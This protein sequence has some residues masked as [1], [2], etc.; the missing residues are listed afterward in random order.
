MV[1]KFY[2]AQDV[3]NADAVA[4][5]ELGVPS[6]LLMEN[7]AASA[8]RHITEKTPRGGTAVMLAG[9][10][11]NG[12]DAF[13]AARQLVS[14]G[15]NAVVFKTAN[16]ESYKNDAALNLSLLKKLCDT[17]AAAP[18][19][20]AV[21]IYDSEL[22]GDDFI[23]AVL[24]KSACICDALL[25]TG[26]HG[27]PRGEIARLIKLLS[28]RGNI[29]AFDIPS[30]IDPASGAVYEPCVSADTTVTFLAP[31]TG[32]AVFPACEK[33][34]AVTVGSI[35]VPP[36]CVLPKEPELR[37]WAASDIAS[38]I[39]GIPAD[40]HKTSRGS[41]L[42][43]AGSAEYRGAPLLAA[44]GA[45]RAGAGLVFLAVPDFIAE[46]ASQSLPEAIIV[47]LETKGGHIQAEKAIK[48]F[49]AYT[50]KCTAAAIGPGCGRGSECRDIFQWFWNTWE[51][52]LLLDADMLYFFALEM[53]GHAAPR[54]NA[55]ITPH[56][57]EAARI[58]G[59]DAAAV[60]ADRMASVRR[61]AGAAGSALLKGRRTLVASAGDRCVNAAAAGAPSLAVPGSGDVL[62]GAAG[63][64]MA[65]GVPAARAAVAAALA[66]GAAG[67]AL[68]KKYGPRG[69]LA[70]EI[71]DEIPFFLR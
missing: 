65:S 45:L 2:S 24:N 13:A 6:S 68:F 41:L 53:A 21:E 57:G 44:R 54:A 11:N 12:G 38:L 35:G 18:T 14:V 26:S 64:M 55:L 51:Q 22:C 19:G 59:I 60:D 49:E 46:G 8:V 40:I 47:P 69:T 61:L 52:P 25:G 66:H 29:T 36:E 3:R 34:G 23:I 5:G 39:P 10:G 30:G 20:P 71:A 37:L 31:K 70:A 62:T 7:A 9:P 42:I 32:M 43:F 17:C 50:L 28:G 56:S 15:R 27:A 67:E 48:T 33:C 1:E 4:S 63:A 58:L 16:D